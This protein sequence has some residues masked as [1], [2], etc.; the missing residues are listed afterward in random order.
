VFAVSR[1]RWGTRRL[2]RSHCGRSA[3]RSHDAHGQAQAPRWCGSMS[4]Y[5]PR[6]G[7]K[8]SSR[9]ASDR[10]FAEEQRAAS[11]PARQGAPSRTE[12]AHVLESTAA[13]PP[14]PAR[15]GERARGREASEWPPRAHAHR[16]RRGGLSL[17]M[18]REEKGQTDQ[19]RT[20]ERCGARFARGTRGR[21][22]VSRDRPP[23][24]SLACVCPHGDERRRPPR[25]RRR[26]S[27]TTSARCAAGAMRG[28]RGAAPR[29]RAP[30]AS[31]RSRSPPPPHPEPSSRNNSNSSRD[32]NQPPNGRHNP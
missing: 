5:L 17:A 25:P 21:A 6:S 22:R 8:L 27:A 11:L 19:H 14:R 26:N 12:L 32:F 24:R 2:R 3:A 7:A 15:E 4:R 29:R 31:R 10:G 1:L 30:R 20:D 9:Q 23:H 13:I 28:R 18:G 16:A